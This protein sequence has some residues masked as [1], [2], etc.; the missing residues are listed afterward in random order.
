MR[1]ELLR[2]HRTGGIL[3]LLLLEPA[4]CTVSGIFGSLDGQVAVTYTTL[5]KLVVGETVVAHE[6]VLELVCVDSESLVAVHTLV[7]SR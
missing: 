3:L 6:L 7:V 5:A 4:G 1:G 2:A